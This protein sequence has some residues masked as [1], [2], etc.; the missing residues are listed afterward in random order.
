VFSNEVNQH[1]A[2]GMDGFIGKP[3]S[4]E[5]LAETLRAAL[6]SGPHRTPARATAKVEVSTAVIDPSQLQEDLRVLG[7]PRTARIVDAFLEH[8]HGYTER[9]VD[10]VRQR[11]DGDAAE[12][13]H[14]LKGAA[15][16]IGLG[17]LQRLCAA[18][19]GAAR[20]GDSAALARSAADLPVVYEDAREQLGAAWEAMR[21]VDADRAGQSL[22]TARR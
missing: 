20:R 15:A 21:A 3:I 12:A 19:E 6:V 13:A 16:S 5:R 10:A 14:A 2:A 4:P 9:L 18:I 17:R 11:N 8:S 1:L 7:E 22:A